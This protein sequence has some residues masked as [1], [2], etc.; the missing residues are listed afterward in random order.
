MIALAAWLSQRHQRAQGE[1]GTGTRPPLLPWFAVAFAILVAI[2]STGWLPAALVK[3]GQF[4]SQWC[5]VMAMVAIGMKTHLKDIL[6]VGWKPV[7][8]MVLET[9]FRAVPVLRHAGS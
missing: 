5:L 8:L 7:A 3:A 6:S 9:L 1:A 2:N 4:A